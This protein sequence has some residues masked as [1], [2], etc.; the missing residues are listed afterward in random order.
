MMAPHTVSNRFARHILS[1]EKN[2]LLFVGYAEDSTPAG[3]ILAQGK[4]G[5]V[6]LTEESE[7]ETK[8]K[9]DVERFDFSGH[10]PREQLA[11]YAIDC[12]P[13]H[14]ILV[15]GDP[16]AKAWFEKE[17]QRKLPSAKISVP[18]PGQWLDLD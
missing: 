17:L 1:S 7:R 11:Q 14:I 2:A 13:D 4:G 5:S 16:V 15:H 10:A 8:I 18:K 12:D 9:C 6:Q 3:K